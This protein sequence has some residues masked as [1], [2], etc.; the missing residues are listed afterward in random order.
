[1]NTP[2]TREQAI[3]RSETATK[4]RNELHAVEETLSKL[5]PVLR[6]QYEQAMSSKGLAD[7]KPE[8]AKDALPNK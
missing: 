3:R 2:I 4:D 1:M 8:L 6:E 5:A 7:A